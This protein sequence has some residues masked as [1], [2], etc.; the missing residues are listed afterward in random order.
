MGTIHVKW[1]LPAASSAE[2]HGITERSPIQNHRAFWEYEK[3][4]QVRTVVDKSQM[5]QECEI[6]FQVFQEFTPNNRHD[7]EYLGNVK[8]NLAEYV[9]Q[10]EPDEGVV[11]RYL[12]QDSKIN[13]TLKVGILMRQIEGDTN[14]TA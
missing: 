12:L 1:N 10:G 7:R 5:L 9:E 2:Q 11:R 13:A 6:E 4:L 3:L 8:L 14:F